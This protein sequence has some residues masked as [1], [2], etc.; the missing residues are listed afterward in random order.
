MPDAHWGYGFPIGGVAAFDPEEG[1]VVSAGGVAFDISC[2]VRTMLTGLSVRDI[3][4]VQADLAE[5]LFRQI[6]AGVGSRSKITL[7]DAE[8]EAMLVGGARWAV[9]NG[10]G[11]ERDLERI[12]EGGRMEGARPEW[13]S[14]R[15][16]NRQ[17][18]EM[19][20]LGSGNHYLEVQ[21]TEQIF[22]KDAAAAYGLHPNGVVVT[23]HCGSRGLGHQIGSEF[24]KENAVA[25]SLIK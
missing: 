1:G 9:E 25:S 11:E 7:D 15:A 13:V 17:R 12:E 14:D 10:W 22:D 19:G 4:P 2:G 18:R 20:T 6:P 8:M 5:S 21:A 16:K 24:L 23:I 3:L